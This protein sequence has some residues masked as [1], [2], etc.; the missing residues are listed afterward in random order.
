MEC[1]IARSFAFIY[2]RNQPNI[3]LLGI[4]LDDDEFHELAKDGEEIEID[5][6]ERKVRIKGKEFG[7]KLEDME[8]KLVEN[9]GMNASYRKFGKVLF[10]EL[11]GGDE[12]EVPEMAYTHDDG[13]EMMQKLQW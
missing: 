3:G 12:E 11:T 10:E 4:V 2:A 7:F 5:P 6:T 9:G 1:V 13:S 8:I